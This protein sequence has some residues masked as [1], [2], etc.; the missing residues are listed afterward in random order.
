[1][2]II[3]FIIGIVGIGFFM[4]LF[5]APVVASL[6]YFN[7]CKFGNNYKNNTR[8]FIITYSIVAIF[9]LVF[10]YLNDVIGIVISILVPVA[11][12]FIFFKVKKSKDCLWKK[13]LLLKYKSYKRFQEPHPD[14]EIPEFIEENFNSENLVKSRIKSIS[15]NHYVR[16][17]NKS[18]FLKGDLI[19]EFTRNF[20][21]RGNCTES[22]TKGIFFG[23][24]HHSIYKT[25]ENSLL[26]EVHSF[27]DE[28]KLQC[29]T[30][31][32]YNKSDKLIDTIVMDNNSNLKSKETFVYSDKDELLEEVVY[33]LNLEISYKTVNSYDEKGNKIKTERISDNEVTNSSTYKYDSNSNLIEEFYSS[34][35][36]YSITMFVYD[37]KEKL[38]EKN[39]H[40]F[41]SESIS[42]SKTDYDNNGN[43]L[44]FY[45]CYN[46]YYQNTLTSKIATFLYDK[47]NR[48]REIT[49]FQGFQRYSFYEKNTDEMKSIYSGNILYDLKGIFRKCLIPKYDLNKVI[50]YFDCDGFEIERKV[51]DSNNVFLE[52]EKFEKSIV[53]EIYYDSIKTFNAKENFSSEVGYTFMNN[54]NCIVERF[55]EY[56][57]K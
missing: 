32:H 50:Q 5:T 15:E 6:E 46:D 7:K 11:L 19:K 21:K 49:N 20:D 31:N 29:I 40:Q 16:I 2:E 35:N 54:K 13:L 1:M 41:T 30:Y 33:N 12:L 34:L 57:E 25:N 42:E 44:R 43:E 17:S 28:N 47:N 22:C 3:Y 23:L 38:I 37:S 14:S 8:D 52:S 18:K 53:K 9:F 24:N 56:Y 27:S 51:Y 48:I 4:L 36:S 26:C 45:E 55:I 10:G 39:E